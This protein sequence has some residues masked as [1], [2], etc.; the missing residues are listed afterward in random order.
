MTQ[1]KLI[2]ASSTQLILFVQDQDCT[3]YGKKI[4]HA[5]LHSVQLI[6]IKT[7]KSVKKI[8]LDS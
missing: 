1:M 2:N 7:F 4:I 3:Y 6:R 8:S 5:N